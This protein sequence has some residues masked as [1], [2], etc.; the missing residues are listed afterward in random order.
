[1]KR[2]ISK[3]Q[4]PANGP[5][6]RLLGCALLAGCATIP[7]T[8]PPAAPGCAAP[9]RPMVRDVLYLG[10]TIPGGG[11]VDAARWARFERDEIAPRLADGATVIDARGLWRDDE[12]GP[13]VEP[14][15]LVVVLHDGSSAMLAAVGDIAARYRETFAQ[16]S[17]LREQ[18]AVCATF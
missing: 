1:M 13:I 4:A 7:Q 11:E 15:R 18:A 5:L 6:G 14:T 10:A 17:V 12:T 9:S 8:T 3:E 16:Q 2:V